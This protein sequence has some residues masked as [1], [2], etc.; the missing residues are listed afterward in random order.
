VVQRLPWDRI[1]RRPP[2]PCR[3]RREWAS[4]RLATSWPQ[5]S[6]PWPIPCPSI[7]R[8]P[9]RT[10]LAAALLT[11]A[12]RSSHRG[13]R[14]CSWW[15]ARPTRYPTPSEILDHVFPGHGGESRLRPR[16]PGPGLL[17]LLAPPT[18]CASLPGLCSAGRPVQHPRPARVRRPA[19]NQQASPRCLTSRRER[20]R[21]S[22]EKGTLTSESLA[23]SWCA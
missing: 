18:P 6:A 12:P 17:P 8:T 11:L 22:H 19:G 7:D 16:G 9:R 1:L 4:R 10:L 20:V 3:P 13:P 21:N 5:G 15:T 23:A 2:A 14:L